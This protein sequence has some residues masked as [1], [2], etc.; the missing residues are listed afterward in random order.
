MSSPL[1]SDIQLSD[2]DDEDEIP[3]PSSHPGAGLGSLPSPPPLP[4]LSSLTRTTWRTSWMVSGTWAQYLIHGTQSEAIDHIL[5]QEEAIRPTANRP[6]RI[7]EFFDTTAVTQAMIDE[8]KDGLRDAL[9]HEWS[10]SVVSQVSRLWEVDPMSALSILSANQLRHPEN[11]LRCCIVVLKVDPRLFFKVF[12]NLFELRSG[13]NVEGELGDGTVYNYRGRALMLDLLTSSTVVTDGTLD[14]NLPGPFMPN[15]KD[16]TYNRANTWLS[17]KPS[18][19]IARTFARELERDIAYLDQHPF[20]RETL[21]EEDMQGTRHNRGISAAALCIN[22]GNR[23]DKELHI[24]SSVGMA[25]W[26]ETDGGLLRKKLQDRVV[27]L[28]R[29]AIRSNPEIV[30][31]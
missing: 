16:L 2:S 4:S 28:L 6:S 31:S 8:P 7:N 21:Q 12:D 14:Y 9:H 18:P 26:R 25:F 27:S 5:T 3:K 30:R 24:S 29:R 10:H 23:V 13:E 1:Y 19:I 20:L 22:E 11:F 17:L 15:K